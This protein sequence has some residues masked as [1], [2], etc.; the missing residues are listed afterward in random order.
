MHRRKIERLLRGA[1]CLSLLA[2]CSRPTPSPITRDPVAS[3]T[4]SSSAAPPPSG[5]PIVVTT[6]ATFGELI[7]KANA[8]TSLAM[9][10]EIEA[11]V[12]GAFEP[13][14]YEM[15]L[16]DACD[17]K[18]GTPAGLPPCR[19][20]SA[21]QTLR[22]VPFTGYTC[23]SQCNLMCDKNAQISGTT[24]RYVVKSCDGKL[25]WESAPVKVK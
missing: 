15:F 11:R 10:V 24:I 8:T 19:T 13:R 7:V 23:S 2:H 3:A 9:R 17:T 16:L 25:R 4:A 22:P 20:V 14:A 6:G 5:P 21:G 12:D 18:L 1:C